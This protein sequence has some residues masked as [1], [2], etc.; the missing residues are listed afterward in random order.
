MSKTTQQKAADRWE[1]VIRKECHAL[2]AEGV[3][4]DKNWEAPKIPG[5]HQ[6]R[7]KSK[8]DFSGHLADGR[9]VVFEA[10]VTK[11]TTSFDFNLITRSRDEND[12]GQWEVLQAA[13]DSGA[14]AFVYVL[15]GE[16]RRWVLPWDVIRYYYR[17]GSSSFP[18]DD[19]SPHRQRGEW[20]RRGAAFYWEGEDWF[21][22]IQRVSQ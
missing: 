9:H 13:H 3:G 17:N 21:S 4:V 22:T 10:K 16:G 5:T 20:H 15:D 6:P 19:H 14:V 1:R 7:E 12:P 18:F 8:P 2:R 11:S